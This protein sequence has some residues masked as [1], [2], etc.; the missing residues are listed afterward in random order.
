MI[1]ERPEGLY[2]PAGDFYVDP[3]SPVRKAII[4]HAHSDHARTGME[5]YLAVVDGN[6]ILRSRLGDQ[7][8]IQWVRYGE[9]IRVGDALVSLHP[10]GHMTG[11]AQV[12]IEVQGRVSVISGDYKRQSDPTCP[13][14]EPIPCHLFVT[15]S[16]FGLPIYSWFDTRE[17]IEGIATWWRSNREAGKSSILFAYSIGKTQRLMAELQSYE[18]PMVGHGAILESVAAYRSCGV[19]LPEVKAVHEKGPG[20]SWSEYLLWA[21]PSAQNSPWLKRFGNVSTATASG[22]MRVRGVRKRRGCDRGFVISDH[23]DWQGLMETI[24]EVRCE[25]V[26]V[27]HG[28]TETVVRYL[29]ELGLSAKEVRTQFQGETAGDANELAGSEQ[30]DGGLES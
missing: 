18:I 10:S 13:S 16:T 9:S 5:S 20:E 30:E 28:Y 23:V 25:E 12:R 15:E 26:W 7:A 14:F 29:K 27:T 22:W 17:E 21:P 3:W 6:A 19:P 11:A 4:T 24:R 2:C 1:V 8:A